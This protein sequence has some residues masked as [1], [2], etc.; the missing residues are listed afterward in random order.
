MVAD[1]TFPTLYNKAKCGKIQVWKIW[2]EDR[3]DGIGVIHTERGYQD[4]K[5]TKGTKEITKGKNIGKANATTPF[6]QAV[7]EAQSTHTKKMKKDQYVE[8]PGVL[9]NRVVKKPMLAQTFGFEGKNANRKKGIVFPCEA[10]PKID[11]IRCMTDVNEM[12]SRNNTQYTNYKKIHEECK[13][14]IVLLATEGSSIEKIIIDGELFT[15]EIPFEELNGVINKKTPIPKMDLVEYHIFDYVDLS[16]PNLTFKERS[17]KLQ[18]IF[19]GYPTKFSKLRLVETVECK[20]PETAKALHA[21]YTRQ[22]YEGLILRN[23]KSVYQM[24]K[25]SYD[26]QKYKEFSD[27][28]FKIVSFEEGTGQDKGTVVWICETDG[29]TE[30]SVR[31]KGDY[32]FRANQLKEAPK[33]IASGAKLTVTFQGT[34]P[35]GVPRFGVGK[36]LRYDA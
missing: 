10:Q 30:F 25:R 32:E 26:L 4:G 31:P 18:V 5:M 24:D 33:I 8:D 28:E 19:V 27:E 1:K 15:S 35:N 13:D 21:A 14:L 2:V 12:Q 34:F 17:E 11:G 6:Q 7:A 16:Q 22:G 9:E 3:E 29:G 23:S 20:T 36:S